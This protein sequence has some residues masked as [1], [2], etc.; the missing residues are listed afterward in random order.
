[1]GRTLQQS[2]SQWNAS[3]GIVQNHH[4][5]DPGLGI[6]GSVDV[7]DERSWPGVH[8]TVVTPDAGAHHANPMIAE[9]RQKA[10]S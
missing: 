8:I 10:H 1:M 3:R 5:F 4:A 2:W 6:T 7:F 9:P